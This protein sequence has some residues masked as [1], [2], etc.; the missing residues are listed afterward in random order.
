MDSDIFDQTCGRWPDILQRLGIEQIPYKKRTR[1]PLCGGKDRFRFDDLEGRG[2]YFCNQCGPGNGMSLLMKKNGWDFKTAVNRVMEVIP[3]LVSTNFQPNVERRSV[4]RAEIARKIWKRSNAVTKGDDVYRYLEGRGLSAPKTI[5][6]ATVPYYD[7]G[8][9]IGKY[10]AMVA[11]IRDESGKEISMHVTYL[12]DGKK[13]NVPSPRKIIASGIKGCAARLFDATDT[14][15]VAEGIETA[16]AVH[17]M[18]RIPVWA[19]LNAGNMEALVIPE[20]VKRVMIYCDNDANFVGQKAGY[21]LANRL[22]DRD[23]TVSFPVDIGDDWAD[24]WFWNAEV[25]QKLEF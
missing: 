24:I 25:R 15:A 18:F 13:A 4:D 12:E 11:V 9:K 7:D 19:A 14:L 1:C 22:A 8:K 5:R 21:T 23:V 6:I 16:L 20:S 2:T 3:G 10:S 17:A